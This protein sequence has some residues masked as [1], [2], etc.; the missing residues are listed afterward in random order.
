MTEQLFATQKLAN[1]IV[2]LNMTELSAGVLRQAERCVLDV[3]A[4]AAA[5][6]N[7]P[8]VEMVEQACRRN[9]S[10]GT[11][12]VWFGEAK[13][14]S[15]GAAM[16]NSNAA[17]ILDLDDGNRQAMGHPGGAIIP[18]VLAVGQE[19]GAS[20]ADMLR[21]IIAGYE[22]AVRVGAAEQRPSYHSAN[23]TSFGVV[24]AICSLRGLDPDRIAH[25]FGIVG[26]YGP[27]LSDLTLS[28]EMSSNVKESMPWSVVVGSIAVD[29]AASGFAGN[30][31]VL[32]IA[33]RID[34]PRLLRGLGE[35]HAICRTYFKKYSCCRWI[36]S[37]IE[38]TLTIMREHDFAADD[39]ENIEVETFTQ[40]YRLNNLTNPKSLEGAQY[41]VPYAIA[42]AVVCGEDHLM[43]VKSGVLGNRQ[44]EALA[45]RVKVV[46]TDRMNAMF[47]DQ[48]PARVT[49]TA[50]G[51]SFERQVDDPW[52]EASRPPKDAELVEKFHTVT[53]D[54]MPHER[55]RAISDLVLGAEDSVGAL[56]KLLHERLP[57]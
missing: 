39:I 25:A 46:A 49:V 21:A 42:V 57:S 3:I 36:H 23:Y 11:A 13:M 34:K 30:R 45:G 33:E 27:R 48:A 55:V 32:D 52:G 44:A 28:T 26:Y 10:S 6:R 47:P 8:S 54:L 56:A 31:D 5:G 41:S 4:C 40:A 1:W 43:P 20:R 35:S 50:A 38:A 15:I 14:S 9:F 12:Q 29:L 37:A 17:T 53:K 16:I 18:V 7:H 2:S 24:A 51:R 22:V 19:L